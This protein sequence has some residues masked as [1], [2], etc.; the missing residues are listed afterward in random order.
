MPVFSPA[1]PGGIAQLLGPTG[2]YLMSYPV[3]AFVA[4]YIAERGKQSL[5]RLSGAAILGEIVLFIGGIG[6]LM[7]LTHTPFLV[8]AHWGFYPF[9]L[10]EVIKIVAAVAIASRFTSSSKLSNLLA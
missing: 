6:W 7:T 1:G 4:G 2:G 5:A 8:A 10:G 9:A 3:A